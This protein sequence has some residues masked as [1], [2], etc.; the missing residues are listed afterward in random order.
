MV[1]AEEKNQETEGARNQNGSKQ[2]YTN[3]KRLTNPSWKEAKAM[4]LEFT[5]LMGEKFVGEKR[6]NSS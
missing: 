5:Y 6:R 1:N 2:K 4:P 3:S